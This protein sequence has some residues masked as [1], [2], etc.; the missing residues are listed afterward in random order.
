[1]PSGF[2]SGLYPPESSLNFNV[3]G[4]LADIVYEIIYFLNPMIYKK[5][6][7]FICRTIEDQTM[8]IPVRSKVY[9]LKNFFT[10]NKTASLMFDKIDGK[11]EES[12]ILDIIKREFDHDPAE[13]QKDFHDLIKDLLEIGA[14]QENV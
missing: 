9:D 6:Q 4:K 8:L 14:V 2:G 12:A 7:D 11:T 10:L 13:I 5:S 1:M 3:R